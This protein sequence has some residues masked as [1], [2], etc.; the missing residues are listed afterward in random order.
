MRMYRA[1]LL[2]LG[3]GIVAVGPAFA[4]PL[5]CSGA[6]IYDSTN[7]TETFPGTNVGTVGSTAGDICQIGDL[8]AADQGNASVAPGSNPS[9]YEFYF[10]GGSLS[11]EEELGNN[12]TETSGIDVELD[13]LASETSTSPAAT[14]ASMHIPYTSAPSGEY[15]LIN[16]QSL[17]GGWYTL[18]NYAGTIADDPRFQAN[19]SFPGAVPEPGSLTLLST[20]L[21]G[22]GGLRRRRR[23]TSR[24]G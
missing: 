14:L 11:I 9:N 17:I 5:T 22:L 16:D 1:A 3:V 24:M 8:S 2:G 13:S 21:V 15:T 7:G 6:G 4:A 18:S 20:A 23:V 19:F 10:A 12:G